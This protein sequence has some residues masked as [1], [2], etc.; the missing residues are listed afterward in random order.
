VSWAARDTEGITGGEWRVQLSPY[1]MKPA[2]TGAVRLRSPD[3]WEPLEIDL[4][5]IS[6]PEAADLA[7]V[8]EGVEIARRFAAAET[9]GG[10]IAGEARP[11]PQEATGD[12]LAAYVRD[13]VRGYFHGVGTCRI[14]PE[15]D[16]RA[17]VDASGAVRGLERL[18]VCD[19]SI[20]PTIPRANTNLTTIAIAER[21]AELLA[22]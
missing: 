4:G 20:M 8:V 22:H 5:L 10:L 3:P 9:L 12:Q 11:G 15:G 14:G 18:H 13:N 16:P 19:A 17:V 21:I 2:S 7:V 1:V 6:D